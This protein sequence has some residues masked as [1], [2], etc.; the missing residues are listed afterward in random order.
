MF[1]AE[2]TIKG[3]SQGKKL[4]PLLNFILF[5]IWI[6]TRGEM[7]IQIAAQHLTVI[8]IIIIIIIKVLL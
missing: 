5:S 3:L 6:L 8:I 7:R 2:L 1:P 4:L